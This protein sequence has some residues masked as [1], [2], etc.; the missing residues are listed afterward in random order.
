[1]FKNY[2][3]IAVRNF[4]KHWFFSLINVL[5]LSVGLACSILLLLYVFD[6]LSYDRF[7]TTADRVVRISFDAKIGEQEILGTVTP[8]PLAATL[9]AEFPEVETAVRIWSFGIPVMRYGDKV[10]SEGKWVFADSTFFQVFPVRLIMGNPTRALAQPRSLV[11]TASTAQRYFGQANPMGKMLTKN[12]SEEL[13]VTG[14]IEDFPGNSHFHFDML[15]SML[16]YSRAEYS[17]W[18]SHQYTTYVLLKE[19]P[20]FAA[21]ETKLEDLVHR[22]VGPQVEATLGITLDQVF[23]SGGRWKYPV[24]PLTSI[25]LSSNLLGDFEPGGDITFV[26][27]LMVVAA[28]IVILATINFMNLATARSATRAKEVGVR[29]TLGAQQSQLVTQ[30]LSESVLLGLISLIIALILIQLVLPVYN[31]FTGK[32]LS[33]PYLDHWWVIPALL[34]FTVFTGLFAGSYPALFMAAFSPVSVMKGGHSVRPGKKY[35]RNGLVVFQFTISMILLVGALVIRGQLHYIRSMPKGFNQ[36][37]LLVVDKFSDLGTQAHIMKE[38]LLGRA[39]ITSASGALQVPGLE[40]NGGINAYQVAGDVE[41][42]ILWST[43]TD[44]DFAET[45]EL[46]LVTGR[47]FSDEMATDTLAVVLNESAVNALGLTDPLNSIIHPPDD[48]DG[49]GE[50]FHVIGIVRDFHFESF[51]QPIHP[52]VF[53]LNRVND[54]GNHLALRVN[55]DDL[56]ATLAAVE[57]QW[58]QFSNG[59]VFEY[60]FYDDVFDIS[61][62]TEQQSSR[63]ITSFAILAIFIACLGLFGLGAF[64]AQQRTKEIGIRKVLGATKTS[65][66]A[67]LSRE[68]V[69]LVVLAALLC[70]PVAYYLMQNWLQNFAYRISLSPIPFLEA[71]FIT[72]IIALV[73]VSYHAVKAALAN[74]VDSLRYE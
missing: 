2:A 54:I 58:D 48:S 55:T 34:A 5:G 63:L 38:N 50:R 53:R 51:H 25:H 8:A 45:Y 22:Y 72:L 52:L 6:E 67:L 10:F 24:Q 65:V 32:I 47:Y 42:H 1:M 49:E 11:I 46:D 3:T 44:A 29:K 13:A 20:N 59:Q 56:P 14:V 69:K 39:D 7:Y 37:H 26:S 17:D 30:F 62:I 70:V 64:M 9:R 19:G 33:V 68:V 16:D 61:Y 15:Q 12:N 71:G 27:I 21:L 31:N 4:L 73:T 36:E 60:F 66:V 35:L 28:F 41:K 18:V 23:E 40:F 74:T 57:A 43:F